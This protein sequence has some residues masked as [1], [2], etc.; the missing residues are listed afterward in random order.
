ME[1]NDAMKDAIMCIKQN[2]V[3]AVLFTADPFH[4][5]LNYIKHCKKQRVKR[6]HESSY[7]ESWANTNVGKH[8]G[9][10]SKDHVLGWWEICVLDNTIWDPLLIFSSLPIDMIWDYDRSSPALGSAPAHQGFPNQ[11]F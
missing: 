4:Q 3:S 2:E 10:L 1:H 9:C 8:W 6:I 11:Q 5:H 7:M